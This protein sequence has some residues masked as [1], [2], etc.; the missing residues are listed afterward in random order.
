LR[1]NGRISSQTTGGGGGVTAGELVQKYEH[2]TRPCARLSPTNL[3]RWLTSSG[4][5]QRRGQ[6]LTIT[7]LG[8]EV[9]SAIFD[10]ADPR[11]KW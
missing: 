10:P 11:R 7:P 9:A 3:E 2:L 8:Y 4:F 6:R 5:A 1:Q